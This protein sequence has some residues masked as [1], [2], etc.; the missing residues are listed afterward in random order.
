MTKLF[1]LL[2]GIVEALAE[3]VSRAQIHDRDRYLDAALN[4]R[5][6]SQRIH[7]LQADVCL[8]P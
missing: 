7:Q 3:S 8:Q 5:E 2:E 4:E 1:I 6:V